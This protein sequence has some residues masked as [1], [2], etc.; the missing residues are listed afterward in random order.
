[1][2]RAEIQRVLRRAVFLDRDGTINE[3][4]HYLYRPEDF[5]FIAGVP[6]AIARLN[7]AGYLVVVVTNQSGVAR[8]YFDLSDVE[9][10]HAYVQR[11]LADVRAHIDG[12][13]VCPHH[14]EH[15]QGALPRD[16]DCRKGQPGLLFKAAAQLHIDLEGSFMVGD[17]PADMEAGTRAGCVPL[18]VM[19]G[20]GAETDKLVAPSI[21]RFPSL[22]EAVDFIL[23]QD[24][25]RRVTA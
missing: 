15:G 21:Q 7:Q 18:L 2:S 13:Y 8:G 1:M 4:R 11:Q 24:G 25:E 12:F 9:A 17:K 14:P 10:L 6:Q 3:E 20:Y 22:V 16:C 5:A 19:T 23:R